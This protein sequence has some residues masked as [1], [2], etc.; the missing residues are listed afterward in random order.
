MPAEIFLDASYAIALSSSTDLHHARALSLADRLEKTPT[1]LVTTRGV[2]LEIGNALAKLRYREA[3]T[4]LLE[5]LESDPQVEIVSISDDLYR[6]A[7]GLYRS[8]TDKEWGL[9]D[10]ASFIVMRDRGVLEALTADEHFRQAGF[11]PLLL[12]EAGP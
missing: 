11:Q 3:A 12:E 1:P 9:T 5:A 8:R 10:C 2:L 7:F 6:R 4:R